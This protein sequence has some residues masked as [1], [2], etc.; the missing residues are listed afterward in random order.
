[1]RG[2][3]LVGG[4]PGSG[5]TTLAGALASELDVPHL[6]KDAVKEALM[7]AVGP[8]SDVEASRRL[9]RMAVLALLGAARGCRAAVI[10]STWYPY[11][12]PLARSLPGPIIE[13]RC[14][15]PLEV[16]RER[17]GRRV[18][19]P[20]HLDGLRTEAELWGEQVAP[21]GLGPLLEV[22]TSRVVDVDRVA[23]SLRSL[24]AP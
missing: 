6:S 12:E 7:D 9:G 24:L 20:R 10:D 11:V 19:D 1:M 14:R 22:D 8:P 23:A 4:W 17:Y 5:K 3:V 13:V 18:R 16:A 2:Y 15:V 21:L